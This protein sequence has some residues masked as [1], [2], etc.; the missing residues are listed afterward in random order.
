MKKAIITGVG[1][2]D[3]AYLARY[4]IDLGYEVY[5]GY[6]RAVSPNFWRLNEL[7]KRYAYRRAKQTRGDKD[8]R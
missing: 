2:Q 4:L 5:G 8:G 6:R 3:G 1:G 7:G